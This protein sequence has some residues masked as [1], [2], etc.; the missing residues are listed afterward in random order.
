MAI[1]TASRETRWRESL[2]A[3]D[4]SELCD[5]DVP[6]PAVAGVAEACGAAVA[7]VKMAASGELGAKPRSSDNTNTQNHNLVSIQTKAAC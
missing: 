4:G 7:F 1:A 3:L 5:C 6:V 2:V